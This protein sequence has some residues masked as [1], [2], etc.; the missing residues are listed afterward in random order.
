MSPARLGDS[1]EGFMK[2]V[3][4]D[5]VEKK[6]CGQSAESKTDGG[7]H[8]GGDNGITEGEC[9]Q[10]YSR[11][12]LPHTDCK[13]SSKATQSSD[14]GFSSHIVAQRKTRVHVDFINSE[15]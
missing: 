1:H 15:F 14:T 13:P 10:S 9:T 4:R 8:P 5:K 12:V 11:I 6:A 3:V 7:F 2:G